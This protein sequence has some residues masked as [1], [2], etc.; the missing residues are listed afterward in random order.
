MNMTVFLRMTGSCIGFRVQGLGFGFRAARARLLMGPT[1][2]TGTWMSFA[3]M[4]PWGVFLK[5]QRP[6]IAK[7]PATWIFRARGGGGRFRV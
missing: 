6:G 1:S 2:V 4:G 7:R 3:Y 5:A